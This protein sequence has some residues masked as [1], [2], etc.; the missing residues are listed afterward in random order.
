MTTTCQACGKPVEA[1]ANRCRSCGRSLVAKSGTASYAAPSPTAA[2]ATTTKTDSE[3]SDYLIHGIIA[4]G[5]G[6]VCFA[7]AALVFRRALFSEQA[8]GLTLLLVFVVGF[9]VPAVYAFNRSYRQSQQAKERKRHGLSRSA[10]F[11][12]A[13]AGTSTRPYVSPTIVNVPTPHYERQR[14][15]YLPAQCPLD[16]G[17][18]HA[19]R[20]LLDPALTDEDIIPRN[21]LFTSL[22]AGDAQ[23]AVIVHSDDDCVIAA[24]YSDEF[25]NYVFLGFT[26][27]EREK[28]IAEGLAAVET[29]MVCAW[30]YGITNDL[31]QSDLI[32]GKNSSDKF[33]SGEPT[34]VDLLTKDTKRLDY[35]KR[36]FGDKMYKTVLDGSRQLLASGKVTK[37]RS[38]SPLIGSSQY[39]DY[40]PIAA[41]VV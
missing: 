9:C 17:L 2:T 29:R 37:L 41:S 3:F 6:V 8:N 23:P 33:A 15:E 16:D 36:L 38:G 10:G 27:R 35:V 22:E 24:L 31:E 25:D 11:T 32:R 21:Y 18:L 20:D 34:I 30:K 28:L 4:L 26:G 1:N 13:T 5:T 14:L 39:L 12:D 40:K 19:W 7:L